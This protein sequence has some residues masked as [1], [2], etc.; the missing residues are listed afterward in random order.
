M[1]IREIL[2]DEDALDISL[3]HTVDTMS[4][5]EE[6]H[7]D[8]KA[9]WSYIYLKFGAEN[10]IKKQAELLKNNLHLLA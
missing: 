7:D 6:K 2:P 5:M 4:I 1:S 9:F 3:H 10:I 8:P